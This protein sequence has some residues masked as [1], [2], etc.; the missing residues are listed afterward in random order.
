[1]AEIQKAARHNFAR[2]ATQV[3]Y[4]G[5]GGVSSSFDQIHT[6]QYSL[7]ETKAIVEVA[8]DYGTFATVHAYHDRSVNRALDAGVRLIQH[9][10]LMSE[11]TVKR[12]AKEDVAL[13]LQAVMSIAVFAEPEKITFFTPDQKAKASQVHDGAKQ[14][15]TW[16]LKHDVLIVSGGDMFGKAFVGQQA[17]N[18]QILTG[19]GFTPF[20]AL[21]SATSDAAEVLTWTGGMNPYKYGTLGTITEGGYAD[22]IIVDGNPL[23]SLDAL[24]RDNVQFVMK[25][26]TVYKNEL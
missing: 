19:L 24:Q 20:Q 2:G 1:M 22:I 12:M 9:G 26:G 14:V 3:K 4:M 25:D 18:I 13:D 10:F 7:E 15:I 21:R 6:T 23:E 17:S 8:K 11:K 16:A 5:G